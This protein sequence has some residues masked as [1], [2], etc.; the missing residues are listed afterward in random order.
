MT[1]TSRGD[2]GIHCDL[3]FKG[4]WGGGSTLRM[5]EM[6]SRM[7]MSRRESS[8]SSKLQRAT[9]TPILC[10]FNDGCGGGVGWISEV[11]LMDG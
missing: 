11:V 9:T 4:W 8:H 10:R 7:T 5:V 3:D 2:G 1:W 6:Q